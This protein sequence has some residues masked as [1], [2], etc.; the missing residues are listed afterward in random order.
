MYG[1]ECEFADKITKAQKP[2]Q[3]TS[4]VAKV[5]RELSRDSEPSSLPLGRRKG[6]T[7]RN[8]KLVSRQHTAFR[9]PGVDKL[10]CADLKCL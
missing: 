2:A 1:F 5:V 7:A 9:R 4:T 10:D 6:I 8:F 3:P